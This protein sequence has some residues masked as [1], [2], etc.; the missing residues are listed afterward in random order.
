MPFNTRVA[1]LNCPIYFPYQIS[2]QGKKKYPDVTYFKINMKKTATIYF[3]SPNKVW[4][5][6]YHIYI[7]KKRA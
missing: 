3:Y 1:H 4:L 6:F 5:V 2:Q 7:L